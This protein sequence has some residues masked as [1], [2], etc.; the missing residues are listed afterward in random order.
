M[1]D[2]RERERFQT[3][4]VIQNDSE[5]VLN[6]PADYQH[7]SPYKT[8]T[9]NSEKRLVSVTLRGGQLTANWK[10]IALG[11][12]FMTAF[13]VLL[14]QCLN[15]NH[16]EEAVHSWSGVVLPALLLISILFLGSGLK[17]LHR[18]GIGRNLRPGRETWNAEFKGQ[19]CEPVNESGPVAKK[20][21][22]N[23]LIGLIVILPIMWLCISKQREDP[24]GNS[25]FG[26]IA[27]VLGLWCTAAAFITIRQVMVGASSHRLKLKLSSFPLFLGQR[28]EMLLTSEDFDVPV[29]VKTITLRCLAEETVIQEFFE[30]DKVRSRRKMRVANEL[31]SEERKSTS[32]AKPSK[33]HQLTFD[34]PYDSSL[35]TKLLQDDPIYWTLRVEGSRGH[36]R[37]DASFLVPIYKS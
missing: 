35:S 36:S 28:A 30:Y 33:Q 25:G 5:S 21:L 11:L 17:T 6:L 12:A 20:T 26:I 1:D 15:S 4:D 2:F 16:I 8:I 31:Y 34:L 24:T 19:R 22:S 18:R 37:V 32:G 9:V 14:A 27:F 3:K 13:I 23:F 7:S 10:A 29:D